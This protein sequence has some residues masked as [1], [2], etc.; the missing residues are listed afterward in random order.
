M[1]ILAYHSF[2][3]ISLLL[4]ILG[5]ASAAVIPPFSTTKPTYESVTNPLST[6]SELWSSDFK[7]PYE[8]NAF[9]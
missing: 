5:N 4:A 1:Q 8:T 9:F 3:T 6:P 7:A 2:I